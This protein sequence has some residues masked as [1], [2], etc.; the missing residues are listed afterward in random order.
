MK[1]SFESKP[2][3]SPRAFEM[4]SSQIEIPSEDDLYC[5]SVEKLRIILR[6]RSL[7]TSGKKKVLIRRLVDCANIEAKC[8]AYNHKDDP[9]D[10]LVDK[11]KL[12]IPQIKIE[13]HSNEVDLL[14]RKRKILQGDVQLLTHTISELRKNPKNKI[15]M[16]IR[17]ERLNEH[18]ITCFELRDESVSLVQ[19]KE[20]ENELANWNNLVEE[21]DKHID[22]AQEYLDQECKSS[23][24]SESMSSKNSSAA[25][26]NCQTSSLK[27]P[28]I[29]LPQ[30]GGELLKFQNFW[31][32][33]EAS[34]HNNDRLPK[35]QKFTYLRSVLKGNALQTIEGFEVT[36][37]NYTPAVEALKHRYGR[38]RLVISSLI[39]SV[40]NM[41][42]NSNMS[43][44]SLR[45]LYDSLMNKTR[46]LEALGESPKDHGCILLPIFETKLPSQLLERWE[47]E[48]TDVEEDDINLDSFL[49]FLNR[50][51][52]SKEAGE[53]NVSSTSGSHAQ[54]KG[55]DW[56]RRPGTEA[57]G[58]Q[59]RV[60]TASTLF[61]EAQPTRATCQF[62][63]AGHDSAECPEFNRKTIDERWQT[64]QASKLC[65]NCLRPSHS[66]HFSKICRQPKCSIADCGRRHHKSLHSQQ[67]KLTPPQEQHTTWS[68]L[69]A[70]NLDKLT[71]T[72]LPTAIAKL[73][74]NGQSISVR[75]LLDSGSQRSYIRKNIAESIGLKGPI[76]SLS[77][78]TLGGKTSETKRLQRVTF[79]LSSSG[80][81]LPQKAMKMEALAIP[82]ICNQLGP[83]KLNLHENPHLKGL[84]FAD[85]YPRDAV[86]IDV[87]IG[88][89]Y[90]YSFVTG[91]CKR[92]N[93]PNSLTAVESNFGWVLTG[94]VK[95]V[96]NHTTSMIAVI[97]NNDINRS[98]KRFWELESMGISDTECSVMSKE[99]ERAVSEFKKGLKFA[100]Q[101]YEV[102]LPWKQE[103]P[104]L[105]DNY[106]QAVKRLE[107]VER[108]LKRDPEK[109]KAYMQAINQYVEKGF[110]EEVSSV[111][112]E[113]NMETR[114]LPHHAVFRND[115]KTTKC[116]IVFDASA[117]DN[118][119]VSLNDCVI[120]GPALQPNLVSVLIRFRTHRVG[121]MA[122]VEKMFLQVKLAPRDQDVHRYLWRDLKSD[123][124]PRTYRMTR[125]TFGVNCSPF[126]AI[127]TVHSHAK[128]YTDSFPKAVNEIL[129]NM[130]V[131]DCLTG[132][133]TVEN[134]LSLQRE[135]TEIMKSAGFNL[136]KW[137]SSSNLV[138]ENIDPEQRAS[139]SL[140]EF[141][142]NEPLKALG[143]SWDLNSDCFK[144]VAPTEVLT[145]EEPT[146]KRRLLSLVSKV[147]DPLGMITPFTI[148]AK[149]L[150][151]ELWQRGMDWDDRLDD[152]IKDEWSLWKAE[153]SQLKD[154]TIPRCFG[155]GA[156]SSSHIDIYGFGDAS[157]KAYGAAVYIRITDKMGHTSSQLV[158]SKSRVAPIKTVS[159][160]R[161][162]LLAAVVNARL[163]KFVVEALR[164]QPHRTV[165]YTD[166]MVALYWIKGNS[167]SWK[168]FVANRVVE[169]QGICNPECWKYCPSKENPADLLTRG[170]TCQDLS[171]CELWWNGP[172]WLSLPVQLH[173]THLNP[174]VSEECEIERRATH[175]CA[176]LVSRP[177]LDMSRYGTWIKLKR[178]AA[179]VLK[180]AK[181][182]KTRSRSSETEPTVEE[183]K[184]AELQCCRW[185][186]QEV[187]R[188]EYAQLKEN[189]TLPNNS[190]ILKLDP[191]YD[192]N[193]QLIKVGGRLQFA[194]IAE[195]V[196][197]SIVLPHGHQVVEKLILDTHK[198]LLHA[199]PETVLASLRD[200]F[201]ITQG[202]RE[203]KGVIRRCVTCQ[204]QKVQAC[205][206][207]MGPL[208]KERVSPSPP[209]TH[210]GVDFAGPLYVKEGPNVKKSYICVFTCASSR[211]VHLELTNSMSTDEFMQAFTRMTSRR[212][213]C[214]TIWSDNAKT[215]KTASDKIRKLYKH[216]NNSNIESQS[217]WDMLDQDRIKTEMAS[218]GIK[219]KFITERSPWRGGWWERMV[220]AVK[221]PLRKVLGKA[222]LTFSE[223]NTL[224]VQIEGTI[225]TRP[226]TAVSDDQ[227]D[228]LPITPAHLAIG[229]PLNNIP[230]VTVEDFSKESSSKIIERYLYLQRVFNCYWKRWE[231][232]YLLRL[233]VRSKWRKEVIPIQVGDI[234]LVSE[235]NVS[236]MKWPLARV[237]E[238]HP[239]KDSLIRTV[240]V[241]TQRGLLNRPVQRLHKLEVNSNSQQDCQRRDITGKGG[242]TTDIPVAS[243]D[244]EPKSCV[245]HE[246]QGGEDVPVRSTRS[247]RTIRAPVKLDL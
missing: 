144:F 54:N 125:L 50:Q 147:F 126:L 131:D 166:S 152:D 49:K 79:A 37:A 78:T 86:E 225:N 89:D 57:N 173:P 60:S 19:E 116:R 99:E 18:R 245:V 243:R 53:R 85:S 113:E 179:Y 117:T 222:L 26:D 182:L 24:S 106:S 77:V 8:L 107:G 186:Q 97:D 62:C 242:E 142:A 197:H 30:F 68:G 61:S 150:L 159:L 7:S 168:P 22:I 187:Y 25:I 239:G 244:P 231:K 221:E 100:G 91:S 141:G 66:K 43:A 17:M 135:L 219:W 146:T 33:F 201:W 224:L 1:K 234:V 119:G 109:A 216:D 102:K 180:A 29:E 195:E 143:V 240:T 220:R 82:K 233:T 155:T 132:A 190:H 199:G 65:F 21:I 14:G 223:M 218:Q 157:P 213:M 200:R 130:Y 196:K 70:T 212:G 176:T 145:A 75:I 124:E 232:E 158:I 93:I 128:K 56:K 4:T 11:D 5:M 207:K 226:L 246:G 247:G 63:K 136:T 103:R 189:R 192:S 20:I 161:L 96:H 178:V 169:I 167:S 104:E 241:R 35:V 81:Q 55:R 184:E 101:N 95:G 31:D 237:E 15:K 185:A 73:S 229:R 67:Q 210:V 172:S 9:T 230:D 58:R 170:M 38:K 94:P 13:K 105:Q 175:S 28:R 134:A 46:S 162:E 127:A 98:L 163:V 16:Q 183:L 76:E 44:S 160:P 34:V 171:T 32:Q 6:T 84:S 194:K 23:D 36:G 71:E 51:V 154:V 90:Y 151:Q 148:R 42:A 111:R 138:M 59:E 3:S 10:L 64:V 206:Q 41:D 133:E 198:K 123:E 227:R 115:K 238:V 88:A 122:D 177:L 208:P 149:I 114:Y 47:L 137:A 83:V 174:Q 40:I 188:E 2:E 52:L 236:R 72:L 27:L 112:K 228:P 204:K 110:A 217:G 202:R 153:L 45:N 80:K 118:Q 92:G 211:M 120:P 87:L 69:A 203:V 165:Y 121:L 12:N 215:F 140:I 108:R 209:F 39:K 181:L 205:G 129:E 193:D 191:Y 48:L 235:D 139:S 214:A 74:A 164:V 156:D